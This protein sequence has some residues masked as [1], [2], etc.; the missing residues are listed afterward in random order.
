MRSLP[1]MKKNNNNQKNQQIFYINMM[2]FKFN[3]IDNRKKYKNQ[4]EKINKC[5]FFNLIYNLN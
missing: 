1:L 2:I 4:R 5:C 3:N